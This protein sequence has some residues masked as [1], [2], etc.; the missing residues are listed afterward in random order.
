MQR[1]SHLPPA[2]LVVLLAAA[3][4]GRATGDADSAGPDT[5]AVPAAAV[6]TTQRTTV[7]STGAAVTIGEPGAG[8]TQSGTQ[9]ATG[10]DTPITRKLRQGEK[11]P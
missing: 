3:C 11:K 6:D 2:A 4:S 8:T 10:V 9:A 5:I 1:L 7:D